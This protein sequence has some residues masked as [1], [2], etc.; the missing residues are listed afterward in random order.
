MGLWFVGSVD[1]PCL[2]MEVTV[3]TFMPLSATTP[4][5]ALNYVQQW[6]HNKR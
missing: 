6:D 1:A 3:V 2:K 5:G 4:V